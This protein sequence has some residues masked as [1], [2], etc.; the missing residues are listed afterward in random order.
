MSHLAGNEDCCSL[1]VERCT[2]P[3]RG[4]V[5]TDLLK[6][7]ACLLRLPL[8]YVADTIYQTFIGRQ[9]ASL[10]LTD[11]CTEESIKVKMST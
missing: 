2:E 7:N 6:I 3:E 5:R 4:D 8:Q 1:A 9:K 10:S 11:I